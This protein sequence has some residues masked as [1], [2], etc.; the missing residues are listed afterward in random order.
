MGLGAALGESAQAEASEVVAHSALADI[1]WMQAQEGGQLLSKIPV[2][3]VAGLEEEGNQGHEQGLGVRVR[4]AQG[5]DALALDLGG[6]LELLEGALTDG[7]IGRDCLDVEQTSVGLKADLSQQREVL[8]A[9][10]DVEVAGIVDGGLGAQAAAF[11]VVLLDPGVLVVD[12]KRGSDS[13]G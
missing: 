11:L 2:G 12:V 6:A 13:L 3:E 5:R 7:A 8:E 4:E 9:L 1:S 10:A